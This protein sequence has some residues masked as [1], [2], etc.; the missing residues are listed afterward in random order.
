M[1]FTCA[2]CE[3]R[4]VKG[5]SK[6]A[7]HEGVVVVTCP[8]CNGKHLMADRKGWFGAKGSVMD[9]LKEKDGKDGGER[10]GER[11]REMGVGSDEDDVL[12]FEN[13]DELNAFLRNR[14]TEKNA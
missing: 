4:S 2:K 1:L 6:K 7:F 14:E 10:K 5:F 12:E 8:G 11:G 13:E 9:F 3:T